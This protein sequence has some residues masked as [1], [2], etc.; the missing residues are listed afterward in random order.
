MS[1][2]LIVYAHPEPQS[3][4]GAMLARASKALVALGHEIKVSDLYAS[5]FDAV[6]AAQDFTAR[7]DADVLRYDRE[8]LYA[9][10]NGAFAREIQDE[11]ERLIWA[12]VVILQFP[13]W[14]FSMPAIMKGWVDRVFV[15]GLVYGGGKWYDRG[16]LKGRRAML[17]V[18]T[19][20][21]PAMC[22]PDGINGDMD[23]ILWPIQNGIL[24]FAGFEVLPPYLAYSVAYRTEAE[25]ARELDR[26][27]DY[28]GGLERMTPLFFHPR[29]DFGEDWRLKSDVTPKATGQLLARR[30]MRDDPA[31]RRQ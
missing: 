11:I 9:H 2:V 12:D 17:A 30:S 26:Y 15:N 3:F 25:R 13:L 14:W 5:Q 16:G 1:K 21:Y 18:S 28:V 23:M 10:E 31:L 29:A 7:G 8:Q 27:G 22:G 24:R 6:A 19:G 20:C 4:N